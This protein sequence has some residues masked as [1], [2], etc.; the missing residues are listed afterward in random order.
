MIGVDIVTIA[1]LSFVLGACFGWAC[2][3]VYDTVKDDDFDVEKHKGCQP[4]GLG[5]SVDWGEPPERE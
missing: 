1:V 5:A 3:D 2:D 4:T